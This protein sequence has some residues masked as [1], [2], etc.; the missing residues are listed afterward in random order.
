MRRRRRGLFRRRR[1]NTRARGLA[2]VQNHVRF[3]SKSYRVFNLN[4]Y[5]PAAAASETNAVAFSTPLQVDKFFHG[6]AQFVRNLD[7]YQWIKFNYFAVKI[8]ELAYFGYQT[9]EKVDGQFI[10]P[11]IT[12]MS[13][14]NYPFYV[15]WDIEEQIAFTKDF[16]VA[17]LCQYQLTKTIRPSSRKKPSFVW[18]VPTPWRRF[19]STAMA[20]QGI[21]ARSLGDFFF[22]LSS[23]RFERCPK[24][25]LGGHVNWWSDS[26]PHTDATPAVPLNVVCGRTELALMYYANVTFRGRS[27]MSEKAAINDTCTVTVSVPFDVKTE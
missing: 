27:V 18:K 12:A 13:T 14:N 26:L 19:Y 16:N 4:W 8:C 11:G 25:L 22:G 21:Q 10:N 3:L 7:Q 5:I 9:P 24:N 1:R 23:V 2:L 15:C 17:D 6:N 20:K